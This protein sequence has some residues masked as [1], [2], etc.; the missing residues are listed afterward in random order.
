MEPKE[1]CSRW[2]THVPPGDR[3]Y[4]KACIDELAR[5]TGL[6]PKTIEKWGTNFERRPNHIL[7]ALDSANTLREVEKALQASKILS[8]DRPL[9]VQPIQ[10]QQLKALTLDLQPLDPQEFCATWVPVLRDKKPYEQGYRKECYQLLSQL[11]G[12][13]EGFISRWWSQPQAVPRLV[14]RHLRALDNL[15]KFQ[16]VVLPPGNLSVTDE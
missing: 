11:T 10:I 3:G 9:P 15:W 7:T 5:V 4:I 14:R 2:V 16:G 8:K 12:Y 6:S 1:F 13:Q